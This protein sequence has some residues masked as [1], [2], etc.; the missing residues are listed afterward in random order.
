MVFRVCVKKTKEAHPSGRILVWNNIPPE[1]E[2]IDS[3]Q[4]PERRSSEET[5]TELKYH[6]AEISLEFQAPSR[7]RNFARRSSRKFLVISSRDSLPRPIIL[8]ATLISR[9][10][11]GYACGK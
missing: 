3:S 1:N 6:V 11:N 4:G 7:A 2:V 9:E 10:L 5:R 8:A